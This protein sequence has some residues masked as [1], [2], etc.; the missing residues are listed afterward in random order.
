MSFM[1][2]RQNDV[3]LWRNVY[4]IKQFFFFLLIKQRVSH[5]FSRVARRLY[6]IKKINKKRCW[7]LLPSENEVSFDARETKRARDKINYRSPFLTHYNM[8]QKQIQI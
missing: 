1:Y 8:I 7:K 2:I 3:R 5:L 4:L 6:R